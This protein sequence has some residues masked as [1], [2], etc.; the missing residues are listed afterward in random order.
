MEAA[1]LL[2]VLIPVV[3]AW[4]SEFAL[5]ANKWAILGKLGGYGYARLPRGK[6]I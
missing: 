3:K 1:T 6:I 2:E 4:P 5:E